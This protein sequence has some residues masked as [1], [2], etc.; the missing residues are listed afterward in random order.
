MFKD[1][2]KQIGKTAVRMRKH[3]GRMAYY[4]GIA[5]ALATIAAAAERYR[6]DDVPP[7]MV[8]QVVPAAG[9]ETDQPEQAETTLL[10]PEGMVLLRA[11]SDHP[12][13]NKV[14][15]HWETHG[16]ADYRCENNAVLSF[17]DGV[18]AAIG[19]SSAYGAYIDVESGEYLLRY[20]S[21]QPQSDF[22]AGMTVS[23]GELLGIANASLP[24]EEY[25]EAHLHL[26]IYRDEI[27]V[28][29][30]AICMNNMDNCD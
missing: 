14:L 19:K 20:A 12:Q 21:V 24:G 5:V 7:E 8:V 29:P 23:A 16:A 15:G 28:D 18:I 1:M 4:A 6:A 22:V 17:S 11:Y 13:W 9:I 2:R 30:E 26:E 3:W 25:E 27:Q 10:K